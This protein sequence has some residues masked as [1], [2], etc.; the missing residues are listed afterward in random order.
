[1]SQVQLLSRLIASYRTLQ[2]R[3]A[4]ETSLGSHAN[5]RHLSQ[6]L[7]DA[8][9]EIVR[10]EADD[11]GVSCSQIEFLLA[12]MTDSGSDVAARAALRDEVL[13]HVRRL[14]GR[15]DRADRSR[16]KPVACRCN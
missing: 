2:S 10:F 14:A 16:R 12:M 8:F 1:M 3:L 4:H 15:A 5:A 9:L 6:A 7:D 11:P 13:N